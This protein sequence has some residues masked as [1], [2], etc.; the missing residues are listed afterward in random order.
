MSDHLAQTPPAT[1]F[2]AAYTYIL[3]DFQALRK[4]KR[5]LSPVDRVLWRW[6]Y[7]LVLGISFA[8]LIGIFWDSELILE[9]VLS[10]SRLSEMLPLVL[11]LIGLLVMVDVVFDWVLVPWVFKRF[12]IADKSLVMTFGH[13]GITWTTEGIKGE[14]AWTKVIRIVTFKGYLF[15]FISKLEALCVPRRA[16]ASEEAFSSLVTYAKER[17]N[18]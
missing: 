3:A 17:V 4:A 16:F 2:S 7:V 12:A 9:D 13:D 14:L 18:G 6:R 11:I 8:V 1:E 5:E 15:L 10:W